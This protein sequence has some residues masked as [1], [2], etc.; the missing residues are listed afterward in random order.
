MAKKGEAKRRPPT[1][2]GRFK[3][4]AEAKRRNIKR[5]KRD[6][7]AKTGSR[8]APIMRAVPT[9]VLSRKVSAGR[10]GPGGEYVGVR[11]GV[12]SRP[13]RDRS[14]YYVG[15]SAGRRIAY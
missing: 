3:T 10:A 5:D 8:S 15:D 4:L 9:K 1:K 13:K 2:A 12:K 7:F 6:R 11:A 14:C